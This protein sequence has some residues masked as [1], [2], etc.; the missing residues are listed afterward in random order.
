MSNLKIEILGNTIHDSNHIMQ[1][2][3]TRN[4]VKL[5]KLFQSCVLALRLVNNWYFDCCWYG[6]VE[7][8]VFQK[9]ASF[10]GAWFNKETEL[11]EGQRSN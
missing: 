5:V 3:T 1:T 8:Y 2:R 10:V 7:Y 4:R 11:L 9:A 6:Q